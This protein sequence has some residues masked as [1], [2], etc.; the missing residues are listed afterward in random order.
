VDVGNSE[1]INPF[2]AISD[3]SFLFSAGY[4][5][6]TPQP[7]TATVSPPASSV[8]LCA[9]VSMPRAIPLNESKPCQA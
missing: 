2:S 7:K 9:A 3:A 5:S 6:S 4:N 8:A 1:M